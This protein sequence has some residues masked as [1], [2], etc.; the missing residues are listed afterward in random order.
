VSQIPEHTNHVGPGWKSIL[1]QLHTDV[2][3][4]D[5]GYEV[6]QVK[7]KFAGLRVYLTYSDQAKG[8]IEAVIRQAET[9]A[10]R[11]CEE[12]GSPGSVRSHP[13]RSHW[14]VTLCEVCVVAIAEGTDE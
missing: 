2:V 7:Q 8:N 14:Y 5:P 12:C 9:V 6:S 4:M 1:D 11:T 10:S 3:A 13:I